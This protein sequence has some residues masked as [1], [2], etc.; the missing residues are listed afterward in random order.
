MLLSAKGLQRLIEDVV[1][2]AEPYKAILVHDVRR[3]GR[4]QDTDESAH[5]EYLCKAA[6][7]PVHVI[8]Q[9]EKCSEARQ[10]TLSL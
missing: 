9:S 7:V 5:Y 1:Q 6:G 2:T 8:L 3:W 4:F 10:R